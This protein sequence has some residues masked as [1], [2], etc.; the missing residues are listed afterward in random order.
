MTPKSPVNTGLFAFC[1]ALKK[2]RPA[3][4]GEPA[5]REPGLGTGRGG[6][7]TGL[8]ELL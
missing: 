8:A 4:G 1:A 7:V 3:L 2:V 5:A 6:D